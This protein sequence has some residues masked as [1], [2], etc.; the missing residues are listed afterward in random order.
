MVRRG[1]MEHSAS[2]MVFMVGVSR[3]WRGRLL[4]RG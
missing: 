4:G 1:V 2:G 3:G